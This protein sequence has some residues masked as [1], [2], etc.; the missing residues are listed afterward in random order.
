[1]FA[2]SAASYRG[3]KCPTL[4][5]AEKTAEKGAEWVTEKLFSMS[6]IWHLCSWPQRL[7]LYVRKLW[8]AIFRTLI[9]R[10][11]WGAS[12]LAGAFRWE[13]EGA[14]R[15]VLREK[16]ATRLFVWTDGGRVIF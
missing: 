12:S 15:R 11:F 9:F 2:I 13:G 16:A 8:A 10:P 4:K 3:A 14:L 6:G 1:M 7:Q 5:T